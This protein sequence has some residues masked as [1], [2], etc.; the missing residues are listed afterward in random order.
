M[1]GT[2]TLTKLVLRRERLIVPLW[3]LLLVALAAGQLQR[4]AAGIG[5][6]GA[7]AREMAA[8][9]AL[10]A[11][12][13]EVPAPTLAGMAVWKNGDAIYTILALIMILTVVRHTRGEEESGRAE[14]VGAGVIGRFAPLTAAL[15]VAC[16]SSVLA[17]LSVAVAMIGAGA[18]A[19]GSVA[20]G[21]AVAAVGVVFAGLGA[22]AAQLTQTA[23]IAVGVAG[24]GLGV[25]YALRFAADGSGVAALKWLSPQGWSHLVR[26][27]GDDNVVVLL[28]SLGCAG[29]A[30]AV[31]YLLLARRDLGHGL[32]PERPGPAGST[33]LRSPLRLAWRLHKGLLTGWIVGYAVAGLVFG[34][35]AASIGEVS[36]QGEAVAEFFRRYTASPEA[37][38]SDAYLWLI[39]LSLGYVAALYP[40]LALLRLRA[41]E[42]SGR[43]ELL[44]AHPVGR[45][46]W[47]AGHLV[48]ALTGSAAILAVA[49]L[50]MGLAIGDPLGVL[51]GT[52]VQVPAVWV[53]AGVGVAAFGLL[54]KAAAAI[55]WGAYLF[56][57]LFGEVLGPILGIDY[58]IAKFL[59]PF[60]NLPMV[61]SGEDF[62]VTPVLIMI[63]LTAALV[64]VGLTGLRR[65]PI[66]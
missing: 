19:A 66:I 51:G 38:M 29:A 13:G 28:L 36:R 15:A 27:Y 63:G 33:G 23:R 31:A 7:F 44:L 39:A 21:A 32:I 9:Q 43:A 59:V 40:L 16:G 65:R 47:A 2:W 20:F 18:A 6:I 53:L 30:I 46:R 64:A 34:A 24:L 37:S 54:P 4:Y 49:G 35:L 3:V 42:Q 8:N 57:N 10:S 45:L 48:L 1:N 12:A 17:G 50:T 41:E 14:L 22:V 25:S 11:F 58:W 61:L 55:S 60:P 52:L 26:P 56:V 62:T 5:D